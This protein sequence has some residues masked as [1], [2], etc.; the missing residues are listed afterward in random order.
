MECIAINQL[1]SLKWGFFQDVIRYSASGVQGIGIWRGKLDE[2]GLAEAADL[3]YEMKMKVSSL[4]WAGGFTGSCGMSH[5]QAID[6]GLEAIEA[7]ATLK[8][9][10]LIVCPGGRNGHTDRHSQRLFRDAMSHLI[11]VARELNVVLA[12]EPM[13]GVESRCWSFLRGINES[14]EALKPFSPEDCGIVLDLFHLGL[15]RDVAR[16]LP[17]IVDRIRLVQI[18]DRSVGNNGNRLLP[19]TGDVSLRA[20]LRLLAHSGYQGPV[21]A[22]IFGAGV[23]YLG[24]DCIVNASAEFLRDSATMYSTILNQ[25]LKS[26]VRK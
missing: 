25:Q 6:D 15:N 11:P 5:Q 7:A 17:S 2:F 24:Y 14:L 10:C 19:E 18:A 26:Q 20:W 1:S 4:S 13:F 12:L 21:E 3:L 23:E 22:E 8:A 16:C 9:G